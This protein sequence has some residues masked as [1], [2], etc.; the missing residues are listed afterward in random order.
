MKNKSTP[1]GTTDLE[2]NRP[3]ARLILLGQFAL[4][5][6]DGEVIQVPTRKNRKMLAI[7]AT[8]NVHH[9][10]RERICA[11]LWGERD[12]EHARSSLRQSLAVLRKELG[13][14]TDSILETNHEIIGFRRDSMS[15]D[16]VEFMK[17]SQISDVPSLKK[18][19]LL[20]Q[21]E[22]LSDIGADNTIFEDWL[23]SERRHFS[24]RAIN[25]FEK[26]AF[27]EKGETAIAIA[28]RLVELDPLRENSHR[29]LMN[30]YA[31]YH[32]NGLALR[33]Y[34]NCRNLLLKELGVE[35]AQ[36]TQELKAHIE[37]NGQLPLE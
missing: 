18:A 17:C 14:L 6:A 26:L 34:E 11:L 32:E 28:K 1:R 9:A 12:D 4:M 15:C 2:L 29:L 8:S 24:D 25:M 10:T 19:T 16:I 23:A 13:R 3:V 30:A 20:Y 37:R 31:N 22:F 33:Q 36:K 5:S 27:L 35:P 7:L 21:G